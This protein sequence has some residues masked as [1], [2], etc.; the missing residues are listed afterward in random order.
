M[1]KCHQ[2]KGFNVIVY[3]NQ[4]HISSLHARKA[5]TKALVRGRDEG[6]GEELLHAIHTTRSFGADVRNLLRDV[7]STQ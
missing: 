3:M 7:E 5:V 4:L 1:G 6:E 2:Q